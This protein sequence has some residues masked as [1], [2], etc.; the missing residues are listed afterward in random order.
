MPPNAPDTLF[1]D[2]DGT[3]TCPRTPAA[4]QAGPRF[5]EHRLLA[6]MCDQAQ[7]VGGLQRRVA[8]QRIHRLFQAK[9]WW[10]WHDFLDALGLEPGPFWRFADQAESL[11]LKPAGEDLPTHLAQLA[12]AGYELMFTSNNPTSGIRHKLR[13]AG[14]SDE[15][16]QRHVSRLLG[17]DTVQAMKWHVRFWRCALQLTGKAAAQVVVIGDTWRDDVQMPR[18]AGIPRQMLLGSTPREEDLRL[19]GLRWVSGWPDIVAQL[20]PCTSTHPAQA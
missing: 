7:R 3:T 13:I 8:E 17:T 20:L 18:Q 1:I 19:E 5:L 16:Q 10:D 14:L 15:W 12:E 11:H 6:L 9:V 2:I 4:E